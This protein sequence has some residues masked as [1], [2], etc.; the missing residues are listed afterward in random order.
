MLYTKEARC[1]KADRS[2]PPRNLLCI[3][4]PH[5][6]SPAFRN[7]AFCTKD[8][9]DCPKAHA[10]VS[11]YRFTAVLQAH[12]NWGAPRTRNHCKA[13]ESDGSAPAPTIDDQTIR[14]MVG[15]D[16]K[17]CSIALW[18]RTTTCLSGEVPPAE[19]E[20]TFTQ[21][22]FVRNQRHCQATTGSLVAIR[23]H[24]GVYGDLS[25]HAPA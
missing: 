23:K 5:R 20:S 24:I 11:D 16:P 9:D 1:Y 2:W 8:R 6:A 7:S 15:L 21:L 14:K 25:L 3:I 12:Q 4:A 22:F 18:I 19:W 13:S 17:R 10:R